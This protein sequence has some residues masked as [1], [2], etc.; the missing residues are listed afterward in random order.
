MIIPSTTAELCSAQ[1]ITNE[2]APPDA[3]AKEQ[4]RCRHAMKLKM[5]TVQCIKTTYDRCVARR[6]LPDSSQALKVSSPVLHP[7]AIESLLS[8]SPFLRGN[9]DSTKTHGL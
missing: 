4:L 9:C 6:P 7:M 8:G 5:A 2:R 1:K 3:R